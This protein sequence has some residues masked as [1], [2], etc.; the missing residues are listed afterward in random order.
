MITTY[1]VVIVGSG[2][3]GLVAALILAKEGKSVCV[4]EKNNQ[5]GGNLQ[6]FSRDKMLFDTGVHYIGGLAKDQNL[7]KYFQYLGIMDELKLHQMDPNGFDVVSFGKNGT[8]YPHAQGYAN[9]VE[10][11]VV[12]FPNEREALE[13]YCSKMQEICNSFPM[14]NFEEGRGGYNDAVISERLSDY[15]DDL[16]DDEQLKAVLL[17]TNFLY[18]ADKEKTPLYVHALT[19]NSYIQSAF[20]CIKGGSQISKL[21]LKQIK[22]YGGEA[23]KNSEVVSFEY[24]GACLKSCTTRDGRIFKGK[25]FI[26]NFNLKQTLNMAGEEHFSKPF[27]KRIKSLEEVTSVFSTYLVLKKDSFSYQ[28]FNRYHYNSVADVWDTKGVCDAQWPYL[29][30]SAMNVDSPEQ[31]WATGITVMTYMDFSEVAAWSDTYNVSTIKDKKQR[32]ADYEAF[33][34]DK[35]AKII[36]RLEEVYPNI[37]A[38]IE[39]VYTSSPLTYRDFIAAE[40]GNMYGFVKDANNPMKTF[41]SPRS[42]VGNLFFSGQNIR[43]HG[44]MGV[45]IGAFVT[46][47]EM[48]DKEAF[49]KKWKMV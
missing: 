18:V 46:C 49:I 4:L 21:L 39:K 8:Q 44:I 19:V 20:R 35:A 28:N 10:Q 37:S 47:M 34:Q 7:E 38:Y 15:I 12:H 30:V 45:T 23:F 13:Q 26:S 36:A 43:M 31:K 17:G 42:K 25:Q 11:L 29:V 24:D 5:F 6:T 33:K 2:M 16:T 3:G 27:I 32:A 40:N 9:F 14:Y 41:I 1:D 22:K 48:L